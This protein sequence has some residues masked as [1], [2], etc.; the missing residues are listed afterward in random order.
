MAAVGPFRIDGEDWETDARGVISRTR[1]PIAAVVR[2]PL[3]ERP[4][5]IK[6]RKE[7]DLARVNEDI[8]TL[9]AEKTQLETDIA[10]LQ[11]ILDNAAP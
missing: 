6:E 1:P 11:T 9:E 7:T 2:N 5:R 8:A 10:R 4:Q 3:R